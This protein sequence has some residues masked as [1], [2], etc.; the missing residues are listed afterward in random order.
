MIGK[1]RPPRLGRWGAPL[2][3]QPGDGALGDA[4][5]QLLQL[6][7]DSGR[8]PQGIRRRHARDQGTEFG[9]HG[10]PTTGGLR[11][12]LDPI[13]AEAPSLPPQDG[14]GSHDQEM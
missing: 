12:Q 5:P 6:A 7:V 10:R 11:G 8:A 13:L 2:R 9:V 3:E 4:D 1:E 14:V